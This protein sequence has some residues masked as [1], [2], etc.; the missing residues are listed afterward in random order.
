NNIDIFKKLTNHQWRDDYEKMW[1]DM[2]LYLYSM[3]TGSKLE[4]KL[5]DDAW[6]VFMDYYNSLTAMSH[7]VPVRF[8]VFIPKAMDYVLRISGLLHVLES[9]MN[10]QQII[11][12]SVSADTVNRAVK[13]VYYFLSQARQIV[14]SYGPKKQKI[15]MDS[16]HVLASI[17]IVYD[18]KNC[19][20]L[21]TEEMHGVYNNSVPNE[22]QIGTIVSFGKLIVKTLKE[23]KI[24]YEKKKL[25]L[26]GKNRQGFIFE[27]ESLE[28]IKKLLE[29]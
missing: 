24:K 15:S 29:L 28:S 3:D 4:L 11:D 16:K 14:E 18:S 7:Y 6:Q 8:R 5:N 2:I 13:L 27:K 26:D 22:A 17:L 12:P 21:P 1:T 25:Y 23:F 10:G 19:L 20:K 9:V